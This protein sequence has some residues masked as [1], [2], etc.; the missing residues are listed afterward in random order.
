MAFKLPPIFIP[1]KG[2]DDFSKSLNK[3]GQN[4]RQVGANLTQ[5]GRTMTMAVTLPV[6]A[7]GVSTLATAA[8]FETG[9]NRV[10]VVSRATAAE[11]EQM[12][13]VARELG[14]TTQFSATQAAD[15]MSF[16]AM[17]G[18]NANETMAALP[19]TLD[20]AAA[21]QMDLARAADISSNILTGFNLEAGELSNVGDMLVATFTRTNTNLEQLGE[22]MKFVA[23]VAS[24]MGIKIEEV[25]AAMGLLGNA[26]IQASMAGTSLRGAL[27][28]LAN[29]SREAV[30]TLNRLGIRKEQVITAEGNVKSLTDVVKAL[31][32]T[33]ASAGDMLQI[34]GQRAGPG[35]AAL[36]QQ[37][38]G[39]LEDLTKTVRDSAGRGGA[40]EVAAAQMKGLDGALLKL[41]S[42]FQ[43]L[44]LAIADSG[45]LEFVTELVTK[46]AAV[47]RRMAE[48]HPAIFKVAT[49]LALVAAV[50]GPLL[51]AVG[52][53]VGLIGTLAVL[54]A[55]PA[56]IAAMAAIKGL[57]ASFAAALGPLALIIAAILIWNHVFNLIADNWQEITDAFTDLE[58]F[59]KTMKF[60]I[61][62]LLGPLAKF[63]GL[64]AYA[65]GEPTGAPEVAGQ[66]GAGLATKADQAEMLMR[67]ENLPESAQLEMLKGGA[68]LETL[69]GPLTVGR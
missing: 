28:K 52:T 67:F 44:Q 10:G 25:S 58:H 15:A 27:A 37:G 6:V 66:T 20:L 11:V 51:I 4:M 1:I 43:E 12:S 5:V 45:I 33:G 46:M 59:V 34:F 3:V 56:F 13:A 35:M 55:N 41:K 16:L 57:A 22:G 23:P 68:K 30:A 50:I 62:D 54:F 63:V 9:M 19:G 2:K 17:A 69:Q 60:F 42:A 24:S 64:G 53:L 26:G 39:A 47:I 32:S 65:T 38:S 48:A 7:M 8:N 14:A 21:G 61:A 18:F 29:P 31:E 36:V 49:V 40:A